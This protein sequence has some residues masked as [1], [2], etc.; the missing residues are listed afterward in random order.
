MDEAVRIDTHR[1][2]LDDIEQARVTSVLFNMIATPFRRFGRDFLNDLRSL[3]LLSPT[4]VL[5]NAHFA[6]LRMAIRRFAY[7][8]RFA[9]GLR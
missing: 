9:R 3:K 7:T 5:E 2:T 8:P 6:R 4:H 1:D